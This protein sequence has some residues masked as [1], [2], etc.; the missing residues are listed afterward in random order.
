MQADG[1]LAATL[2]QGRLARVMTDGN[3]GQSPQ[4]P[5]TC[6]AMHLPARAAGTG[7]SIMAQADGEPLDTDAA[8]AGEASLKS[9]KFVF[10]DGAVYGELRSR[11][12]SLAR[13]PPDPTGS[14]C[15]R[16]A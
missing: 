15:W 8:G 16:D 9:G 3:P 5:R 11:S 14:A 6:V 13:G 7:V 2:C 4:P 1:A 10:G 12:P